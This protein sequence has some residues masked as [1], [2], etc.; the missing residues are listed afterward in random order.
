MNDSS[1]RDDGNHGQRA[2]EGAVPSK[3]SLTRRGALQSIGGG[4]LG[5]ALG[6]G[7]PGVAAAQATAAATPAAS[8]ATGQMPYKNVRIIELSQTLAG[9]LTGLMFA[10]Q[11]A[12]VYVERDKPSA[13]FD[14]A[15]FDRGKML[16]PARALADTASA[17]VIIVDGD[18]PVKRLP[19][20][21]VMRVV[22]ALPGDPDYGYLPA[23]CSED[24]ISGL[25]GF[26]TNMSVTGPM[27]GRPV[28][29]TPLPL[30]SVY[31]GVNGAVAV[32][33]VLVDR[34]RT[35]LGREVHA[36]RIAGGLSAIG[37]LAL[38]SSG[39]PPHLEPIVIGGLPPGMSPEQAK[40]IM[41]R[42]MAEPAGQL[43]L[44]QRVAPLSAPYRCADGR[45]LLPMAAPNRRLTRRALEAL[46]LWDKAL[47]AGM[48]DANTF[49]PA[50]LPNRHNNLADSLPTAWPW[51]LSAPGRTG[52][53]TARRAKPA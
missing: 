11:G 16:L 5:A 13:E 7:L 19:H 39:L 47:A 29:Y 17:D 31:T 38:T 33:A 9:R 46:G 53:C 22:A 42:A 15:Y 26:F 14:D 27:L 6:A 37:A 36:S 30:A 10:D 25:V 43:Y 12:E 34:E 2:N 4:T 1:K 49:D 45:F 52:W 48:V 3:P 35:G 50:N 20:Q 44:E 21:I 40:V 8:S 28:I 23:N 41:G 24:L 32:A 18:V 51:P